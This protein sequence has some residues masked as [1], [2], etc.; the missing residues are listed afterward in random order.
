VLNLKQLLQLPM[1]SWVH[2]LPMARV[3]NTYYY[4]FKGLRYAAGLF[5]MFS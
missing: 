3:T 4:L 5:N 1:L 2:P